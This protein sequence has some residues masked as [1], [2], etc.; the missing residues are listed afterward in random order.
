MPHWFSD[1]KAFRRDPLTF[2]LDRGVAT[3]SGLSRLHLG[4][5]P[6][7]LVVD[8]SLARQITRAEETSFDKGA[9]IAKLRP[10]MG[11]S[12]MT[13]SGPQHRERRGALH[14]ILARG[15]VER[16]L[17]ELA[18]EVRSSLAHAAY[19]KRF[20]ARELGAT[21]A[22]RLVM[23]AVFGQNVLSDADEQ[24][25][26]L[27]VKTVENDI[28]DEM[29]R[30]LPLLPWER[31]RR[32]RQRA[33]ARSAMLDIVRRVRDR[34][35][36]TSAVE[37]L[38]QAGLADD[39]L[40]DEVLAL[41]LAGHHTTAA[42]IAWILHH[43]SSDP[44]LLDAIRDEAIEA[45]RDGEMSSASLKDAAISSAFVK[46]CLRLYPSGWWYVREAQKDMSFA[47]QQLRRGS[48]MMICPWLFHRD[49]RHW[50]D[51][52][53]FR[54]DRDYGSRHFIP[55]GTG[56]RACV[57]MGLAMLEMQLIVLEFAGAFDLKSFPDDLRPVGSV[58]LQPPRIIVEV[59]PAP[60]TSSRVMPATPL[61]S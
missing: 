32:E 55:F 24:T 11:D 36:H 34:V 54:I 9:H 3:T 46:E 39:E 15:A 22:L 30:L 14:A 38:S 6:Y 8:P 12:S 1:V 2:V 43:L 60:P 35:A 17:P 21:L 45:S 61:A 19:V 57:G 28:S 53:A 59:Q 7:Y 5:T 52:E 48:V 41:L 13:M 23:V 31:K 27:A 4:P 47:G 16:L 51:P 37:V 49:P 42:G 10:I 26:V 58:T 56:P 20:D 50:D 25:I 40:C 44:A 33:Q 18:A 29:F